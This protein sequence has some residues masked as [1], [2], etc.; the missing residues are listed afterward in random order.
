[1]CVFLSVSL[2]PNDGKLEKLVMPLTHLKQ[3]GAYQVDVS[4]SITLSCIMS[5]WRMVVS[6]SLTIKSFVQLFIF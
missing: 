3:D 5:G 2:A 1:M 6:F 4:D